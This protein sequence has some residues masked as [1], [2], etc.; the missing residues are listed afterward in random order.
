MEEIYLIHVAKKYD[1]ACSSRPYAKQPM[2][3]EHKSAEHK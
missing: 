3:I 2:K 1:E